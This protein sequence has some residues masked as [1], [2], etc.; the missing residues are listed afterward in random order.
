MFDAGDMEVLA[1]GEM[2]LLSTG[3]RSFVL[4]RTKKGEY[5][6]VRNICPHQGVDLS[7]GVLTGRFMPSEAGKYE[8]VDD[9]EILRCGRHAYEFDVRTGQSWFDPDH[10]RIK[11][12]AVTVAEGRVLV[13]ID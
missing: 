4:A 8:Y 2:R 11:S 6:A 7:K 10:V 9:C 5:Y 13:E 12:Y 1:P 3:A